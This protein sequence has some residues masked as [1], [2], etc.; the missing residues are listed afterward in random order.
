MREYILILLLLIIFNTAKIVAQQD[1]KIDEILVTGSKA[2]YPE[3]K[4]SDEQ[5]KLIA[6]RD[7]GDIFKSITGFGVI[8]RGGYAMEPVFRSFK[9]EQLNMM[10]DG[11]LRMSPACPNRMDPNTTHVNPGEIE[12]IE[13][14]KGPYSVRYGQTMG[15]II[16]VI[17]QRPHYSEQ[18]EFHGE[19]VLGYETN[20]GGKSGRLAL[21][22]G[23]ERFDFSLSGGLKDYG[24]YESGSGQEIASSFKNYDYAT[25][26]GLNLTSTQRIAL[27]WRQSFARDV[28]HAALPMDT[29][30]DNSSALTFDYS[31]KKISDLIFAVNVKAYYNDVDHLMSNLNRPNYK[32]VH[33][34]T[35][36]YAKS[37]GGKAEL[38]LSL[39]D[40]NM[41]YAGADY[42]YVWKD[43]SRTRDVF[44]NAC[45]GMPVPNPPRTFIDKVWQDSH[46]S[47]M[48]FYLENKN[49]LNDR[50]NLNAG[51]RFDLSQGEILDPEEDFLNLYGSDLKTE[52]LS[53]VSGM[54]SLNYDLNDFYALQLAIGRGV[55]AP[56]IAER[57][58]N[59]FSV[60]LDAYEYVGNPFLKSEK[61]NQLDLTLNKSG[62][63]FSFQANVFFSYM[64]DYISAF[65]DTTINKKFLPCNPPA[66]AKRYTNIDKATQYGFELS[67]SYRFLQFWSVDG[68]VYYTHAQNHDA[69]EPLS[70]IPPLSS[71]VSINYKQE[72][73]FGV[74]STR[75]VAGQERVS[76][77]FNE[78]PTPSFGTLDLKL[79]YK[80]LG[81]MEIDFAVNNIFDANYY[82]HLS[83]PYK[84]MTESSKFY[85]PGR[86]FI[87]TLRMKF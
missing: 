3:A 59:H 44:I 76:V 14:I 65:V 17:T 35:P 53:D 34:V 72:K 82:E 79:A 5:I 45:T 60:G 62:Q 32:V 43:G 16:N 38:G 21:S 47:T 78:S 33:A 86:N 85:E 18:L 36:V 56:K 15:G 83:R 87:F 42:N 28:M 2:E 51:I 69:D 39:T 67:A 29:E 55:R 57:Y 4:V 64:T 70:E 37:Y 6:P 10:F 8:K 46:T 9:M 7:I 31:A 26:L 74:L 66:N 54:L 81:F 12:K 20:G 22:T 84:N 52:T 48:G 73:F 30:T 27:S 80:P 1:I 58:I 24:N 25:K 49:K 71:T 63:S 75:L 50:L 23:N 13:I 61:N 41:L 40:N 68:N 11:S 19:G 77:Q